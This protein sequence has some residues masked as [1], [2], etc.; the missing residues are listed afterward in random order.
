[1]TPEEWNKKHRK[2]VRDTREYAPVTCPY[3]G[4]KMFYPFAREPFATEDVVRC[5][6]KESCCQTVIN[7][8]N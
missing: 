5:S 8:P 1:M 7:R 6:S 4:S 3:C 2:Q